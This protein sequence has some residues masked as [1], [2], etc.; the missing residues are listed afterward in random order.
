M[1]AK[2]IFQGK[3]DPPQLP[4]LWG[5]K[6]IDVSHRESI[7]F[8]LIEGGMGSGEPSVIIVSE[9]TGQIPDHPN[10]FILQ[11]SLDKLLIAAQ[12]FY[13]GATERWGWKWPA[14]GFTLMP[15]SKAARKTL[16][17]SIKKQ[18]EEWDEVEDGLG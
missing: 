10:T 11:T 13:T 3:K 9:P 8:V 4:H 6:V 17:E 2:L 16:L 15:M 7:S 18:L 5:P 14:G 12:G 1:E